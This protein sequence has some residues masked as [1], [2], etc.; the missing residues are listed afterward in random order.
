MINYVVGDAIIIGVTEAF[1]KTG[2]II[3]SL[4]LFKIFNI[5][6]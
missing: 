6:F 2:V 4:V 5:D 3:A 1:A